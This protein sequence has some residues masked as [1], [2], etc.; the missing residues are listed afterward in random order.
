MFILTSVG[1]GEGTREGKMV[2]DDVG[3]KVGEGDG[4]G[5]GRICCKHE[6]KCT[7]SNLTH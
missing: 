2:G 1:I 5:V 3:L 7:Y 6:Q 4:F